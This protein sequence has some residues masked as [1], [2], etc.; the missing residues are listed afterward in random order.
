MQEHVLS[1][2]RSPVASLRSKI[3]ASSSLPRRS[4]I[5]RGLCIEDNHSYKLP[6]NLMHDI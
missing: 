3:D 5:D 1:G 6:V 2:V 4:Y